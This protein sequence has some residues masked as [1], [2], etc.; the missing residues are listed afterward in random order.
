MSVDMICSDSTIYIYSTAA[1]FNCRELLCNISLNEILESKYGYKCFIP[2][3]DG[4]EDQFEFIKLT[5]KEEYKKL[6]NNNEITEEE[7]S[8]CLQY[9]IY[10]V[11]MAY[12]IPNSHVVL[13]HIDEPMDEGVVVEL[14]WYR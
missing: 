14:T 2:Q 8:T 12:F 10:L 4:F 3:R 13:G 11:D 9:L 7:I 1:L 6:N 5:L